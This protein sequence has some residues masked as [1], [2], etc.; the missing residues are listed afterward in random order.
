MNEINLF[1]DKKDCCGCG[2]CMN[3]CPK[4]A[5][6]MEE[7]EYGFVYPKINTEQCVECGACKRVCGYQNVP[8]KHSA[9][10]VYAAAAKNDSILKK[11]AS[12]GAFAVLAE[13]LIDRGG[14]VYG[15]A[16]PYENGKLEPKHIRI[17]N[18]DDIVKL[19]GSKYVQSD[20]GFVFQ[21][22]RKDLQSGKSVMFSGTPC[23]I[24]GLKKFLN[25]DY[26]GLLLVEIICHGVPS[27]KLFQDFIESYGKQL[28]GTIE[29]FYFRDKSKGQGYLTR[30]SYRKNNSLNNKYS[31]S[32]SYMHFFSK[33]SI[34]RLNCYSCP[35]ASGKRIADIALGDFWGFHE[36]YPDYKESQGLSNGKGISCVIVNTEKG[37]GAIE[38]CKDSFVLMDSEFEKAARHNDQLSK[39]SKYSPQ[40]ETVLDLYKSSGYKAVEKYYKKKFRKD[41]IKY[42]I[43][44]ILPKGFKRKIKQL[45]GKKRNRNRVK[46]FR[47]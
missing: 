41:I 8:E 2:A 31:S 6:T 20:T 37:I 46:L 45:I 30:V 34:L 47:Y 14:I 29:E 32:L 42:R 13:K 36:E 35:F 10:A 5:I 11:S 39:P 44:G 9:K 27:K 26:D 23:Q 24:A 16:M 12:G 21:Q 4:S 28:G 15:A 19:Q 38:E 17:D 25:K 3:I 40:R 43:S 7:D 18:K 22:V 1:N 33:S